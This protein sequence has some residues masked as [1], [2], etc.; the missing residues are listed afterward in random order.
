[1]SR[2]TLVSSQGHSCR[3]RYSDLDTG[4]MPKKQF[5]GY[6]GFSVG[7]KRGAAQADTTDVF[8]VIILIKC[9]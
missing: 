4:S 5:S 9:F 7:L 3:C 8:V 6:Y 1:M 2:N